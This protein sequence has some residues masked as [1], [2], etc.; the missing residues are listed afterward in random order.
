MKENK[1]MRILFYA[2]FLVGIDILNALY[3]YN[4]QHKNADVVMNSF[5]KNLIISLIFFLLYCLWRAYRSSRD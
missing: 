5:G 3:S 2:L 1:N 4:I